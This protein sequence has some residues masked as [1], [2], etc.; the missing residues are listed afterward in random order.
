MIDTKD[1]SV[2]RVPREDV[3][4][5]VTYCT[6]LGIREAVLIYANCRHE[7]HVVRASGVRVHAWSLRIDG[8]IADV[9]AEVARVARLFRSLRPD[10]AV[11][12]PV[13]SR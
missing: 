5:V 2:D 1:K 11:A 6:A 4:Q 12:S 9:Q 10:A 13:G 3:H 7:T 8:T